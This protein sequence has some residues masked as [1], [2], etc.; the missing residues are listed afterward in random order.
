MVAGVDFLYNSASVDRAYS[1]EVCTV[2]N[3]S[4]AAMK[5]TRVIY[6]SVIH[7]FPPR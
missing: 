1:I 4:P 3:L 6:C 2:S 7:E 5:L